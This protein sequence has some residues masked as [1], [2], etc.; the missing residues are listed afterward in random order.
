MKKEANLKMKL[1][2]SKNMV[3]AKKNTSLRRSF[4]T[5]QGVEG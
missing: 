5:F 4:I 2:F 3:K 1:F